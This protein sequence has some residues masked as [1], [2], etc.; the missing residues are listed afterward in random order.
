M[1]KPRLNALLWHNLASQCSGEE[2]G[3]KLSTPSQAASGVPGL[4]EVLSG[5][6][7]R[8]SLFLIEGQPGTG[9][10]TMALQFLLEGARAGE[11]NLCITLS[12]TKAELLDGA[13]SHGWTLGPNI[14]VFE[15]QPAE[16]VLDPEQQ[17]SLLYSSELELGET[18]KLIFE[19]VERIRPDRIVLDSLSEIRLLAQSSLRYRR[20]LLALKHYFARSNATILTLDDLTS[21]VLDKTAHSIAHGVIRLEELAP[22]YG[23]ERRRMRVM[24]YRGHAFRGGYHDFIISTD[25]VEIFPRLVSKEYV[26]TVSHTVFSSGNNELDALLGGGADGGSS[27]LVLGPAGCGKSLIV[28]QFAVAAIRRGERAALFAFDEEL[29]LLF[30]RTKGMGI[31]LE[32]FRNEG[33]LLVQQ[34]DA[35]ELSPGE[36]SHR[37]RECVEQNSVRT[38]IIDSLNGYQLAMPEEKSLILHMHELLQ[39]LNRR[40]VA[41]FV[42]VA[43]HGLVGDMKTPVDVTYLADTVILLRFFEAEGKIRRA[44]SVIKKRTGTHEDTIHELKITSQGLVVGDALEDYHGILRGV[45]SLPGTSKET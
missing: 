34:I 24:K 15:L 10:T 43:Q 4:D 45:P 13:A 7:T 14:E 28:F 3:G 18:V 41:T 9:K 20:Q 19:I 2:K 11:S 26:G 31:D 8:G 35:A 33:G 32:G 16:T 29:G 37:V 40:G 12:E 17:Q 36:F 22:T 38:V 23:G 44:I 27:T 30:R 42:T 6:F 21:D 5:G 1:E 25:G 39:Y